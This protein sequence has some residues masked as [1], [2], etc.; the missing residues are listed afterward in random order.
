MYQMKAHFKVF[1]KRVFYHS[2]RSQSLGYDSARGFSDAVVG[3]SFTMKEQSVP[4]K[5][6]IIRTLQLNF[7]PCQQKIVV[8]NSVNLHR[9]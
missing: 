6:N 7:I 1:S 3:D 8:S 2:G 4:P 5:I 9:C